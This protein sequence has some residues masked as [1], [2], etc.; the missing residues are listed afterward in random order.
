MQ[1]D[2]TII[3][4]KVCHYIAYTEV[5]YALMHKLYFEITS[6][7]EVGHISYLQRKKVA[8]LAKKTIVA[9]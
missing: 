3:S 9:F 4:K 6:P 7:E 5:E 1:G 2:Q 8:I